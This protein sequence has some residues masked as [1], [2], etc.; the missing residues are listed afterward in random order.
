MIAPL[1]SLLLLAGPADAAAAHAAATG[2]ELP[3]KPAKKPGKD[4][5]TSL[6]QEQR[7]RVLEE[8]LRQPLSERLEQAS[9]RFLDTPYVVSPLGE[10]KGKDPDPT[11]RYD[12]VDC[13][14]FVEET[15]A[16]ALAKGP[17]DVE[18]LLRELR[19]AHDVRYEDRNHLMEAQWLPNN[20]KKGFVRDVTRVYGGADTVQ[21]TKRITKAAW[22]SGLARAL[23]LPPDRHITGDFPMDLLPLDKVV[24]KAPALPTG[25]VMVVVRED[26]PF[27]VTR[28]THLGFVVQKDGRTFMRHAAM[29]VYGRV[30]DEEMSHF[31][32]RN[33]KYDKWR[34][35]GVLL[36]EVR[37]P[38][39]ASRLSAQPAP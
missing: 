15:I 19:Y 24:S 16:L 1:L 23:D 22:S 38:D 9:R 13:L 28:I 5:W 26:A 31:V 8:Y 27:R 3:A 39:D 21:V 18:P 7:V 10:G 25:T 30:V 34:V 2:F 32:G 29:S 11:L 36:L 14:T 17:E 20:E 33:L 4:A 35:T 12:A 6:S 37:A